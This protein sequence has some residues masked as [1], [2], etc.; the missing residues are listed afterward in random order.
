MKAIKL[1]E[2]EISFI[3]STE[4]F[5]QKIAALILLFLKQL[6]FYKGLVI[7]MEISVKTA[8]Q[9][10]KYKIKKIQKH[11]PKLYKNLQKKYIYTFFVK[12][13]PIILQEFLYN[14]KL[15]KIASQMFC[16]KHYK[17]V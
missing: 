8:S 7:K 11:N 5:R 12:L 16:I 14:L 3:V 13:N 15:R 10:S 2:Y 1:Y 17:V 6:T 9:Y 4:E